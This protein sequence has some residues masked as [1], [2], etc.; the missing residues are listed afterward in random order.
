M[1]LF[2]V[3]NLT[4]SKS[5]FGQIKREDEMHLLK[6]FCNL[7]RGILDFQLRFPPQ[8]YYPPPLIF[9][10]LKKKNYFCV[11]NSSKL[12]FYHIFVKKTLGN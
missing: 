5:L 6:R 8:I 12:H 7:I 10:V 4:L 9:G 11:G 1:H 2:V 3:R